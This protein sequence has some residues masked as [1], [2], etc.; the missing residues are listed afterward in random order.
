[1]T[2]KSP[3]CGAGNPDHGFDGR[4]HA[5]VSP[6]R[7]DIDRGTSKSRGR[8]EEKPLRIIIVALAGAVLFAASLLLLPGPSSDVP[9]SPTHAGISYTSHV[10][11]S[12]SGDAQFNNTN[13]PNNGVVSGNG[14]AS[15]P[16]LISGWDI[17][18][19]TDAIYIGST[20]SYFVVRD[21]YVHGASNYGIHLQTCVNGILDNNTCSSSGSGG[22][23]LQRSNGNTLVNNN[24]SYNGYCGIVL[25][26]ASDNVLRNNTFSNSNNPTIGW[27]MTLNTHSNRNIISWNKVCN[28]LSYG[29]Y[30]AGSDNNKFWNNTFIGNRGGGNQAYDSGTGNLWNIAG[31]PHGYGNYWSDWTTPDSNLDGIVDN[32]YVL[33]GTSGAKDYYPLT[34]TPPDPIP[35]FGSM[36]LVMTVL[37][38]AI[39]LTRE[40]GRRKAQ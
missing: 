17:S 8:R 36:P 26:E 4:N 30:I 11:I 40:A 39:V 14:S 24:C 37:L 10:T 32:P 1:V 5:K 2:I 19:G 35:E 7:P 28:C 22:I 23:C 3:G 12:I 9:P 20:T 6:R 16:Y 33:T 25:N 21:C 27:G 34:T 38:M 18:G 31:S 15:N 29:A 13:F